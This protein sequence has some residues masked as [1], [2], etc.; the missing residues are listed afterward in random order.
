MVAIGELDKRLTF[1][2][3]TDTPNDD[4]AITPA[5]SGEF[6]CWAK[7]RQVSGGQ[8][9]GSVQ[10]GSA[11]THRIIIRQRRGLTVDYEAFFEPP[12]LPPRTFRIK[13]ITEL[14]EGGR[15]LQLDVEEL[16]ITN[17]EAIQPVY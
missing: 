10:I 9:Q 7:I 16:G 5:Y 2:Q 8:Y 17:G 1:R 11:V 3:R 6:T 15:F 12:Y 13:K 4:M 14:A